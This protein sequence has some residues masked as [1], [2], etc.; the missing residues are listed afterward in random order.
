[1]VALAQ[2]FPARAAPAAAPAPAP[3]AVTPQQVLDA[4]AK[5]KEYLYSQEKDGNWELVP[6]PTG[7]GN[8]DVSGAQWGGRT[9][10]ATLALIASGESPTDPRISAAVKF[11]VPAELQGI[12]ALGLHAQLL[13]LLPQSDDVRAAELRDGKLLLHAIAEAGDAKGFYGY[14]IKHGGEH[15]SPSQFAVLGMW[16][17]SEAGVEVSDDYWKLVDTSWRRTQRSDGGW[18]YHLK[19]DEHPKPPAQPEGSKP[20][21]TAAGVA[22]LFITKTML[23]ASTAVDCEYPP[24]PDEALD[25]G[26]KYLGDN[27]KKIDTL[28]CL[29]GMERIGLASGRRDIGGNDW[30]QFGANLI[31]KLQQ[32]D[33][34]VSHGYGPIPDTSFALLFMSRGSAPIVMQKL[35]YKADN[36]GGR[37]G[38]GDSFWEQRPRDAANLVNWMGRQLETTLAWQSVDISEPEEAFHDAPVLYISGPAEPKFT[39]ADKAKL[40]QY[41]EE[42]GL[43]AGNANCN[44]AAFKTWFLKLGKE[45][46]PKY[47]FRDLPAKH[48]IFVNEQFPFVGGKA[49]PEVSGMSNEVREL[50]VLLDGDPSA[51]WQAQAKVSKKN[52]FEIGSNVYLYASG[53]AADHLRRRGETYFVRAS[54]TAQPAV[55]LK[56][57]RIKYQGNW[58]PE[59]AGWIRLAAILQ[60]ANKL[61]LDVDTVELGKG[62]LLGYKLAH[63]TGTAGVKFSPAE[64]TA[65]KAYVAGGGTLLIDAAGG[66]PEFVTTVTDQLCKL[67]TTEPAGEEGIPPLGE[68]DPLYTTGGAL[69]VQFRPYSRKVGTYHTWH[70][71]HLRA[72]TVNNRKAVY[73]SQEDLSAGLVGATADGI[74]GYEPETAVELVS[75][76][77]MS[78]AGPL[79]VAPPAPPAK[80]VAEPAKPVAAPAAKPAAKP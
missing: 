76:L 69:K 19:A 6:A 62:D 32:A 11:I 33:G 4:I 7:G 47:E 63:L 64:L 14:T 79:P 78:L 10:L 72:I 61:Q 53:S 70:E 46:F 30:Y 43:I 27:F 58:D 59:P 77:V 41:V 45:L 1:M 35:Q 51:A 26:L 29:Y 71:P 50:M 48:P 12:Y 13:A 44:K 66:S 15:H 52:A 68:G 56:L 73:F 40:R 54:A 80:P 60:N 25:A 38:S 3:V 23:G 17:L 57:A 20:S 22:T 39:D 5:A 75:R 74:N 8:A 16:Q 18:S 42:G 37:Q 49:H 67:F 9:S 24:R 34:S 36:P 31:I 65:L 2:G 28:Y 21:M 55:H